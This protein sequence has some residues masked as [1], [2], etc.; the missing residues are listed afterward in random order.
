METC[1]LK[2]V[3]EKEHKESLRAECGI[4]RERVLGSGRS[5]KEKKFGLLTGCNH[6]FCLGCIREWRGVLAQSKEV[7]RGCPICR[8]QTYFIV[9]FDRLV[10]DKQRK[11]RII[12][13]YKENLSHIRC[14]HFDAH[15]DCPFQ[16][17]CFYK[18]VMPN[19]EVVDKKVVLN[20]RT[21]YEDDGTATTEVIRDV[22]LAEFIFDDSD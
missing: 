21:K 17:S 12:E 22:L 18:H 11:K 2:G 10:V 8:A 6:A 14:K 9:P 13:M 19:G 3:L 15:Q 5:A 7:V 20:Y 16:N 1:P 4:C